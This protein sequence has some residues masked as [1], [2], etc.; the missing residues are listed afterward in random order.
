MIFDLSFTKD[1][2][3][4][5]F[6]LQYSYDKYPK[7][8][9]KPT[10]NE[11]ITTSKYF[12]IEPDKGLRI[13]LH[14][15]DLTFREDSPTNPRTELRGFPKLYDNKHYIAEWNQ[16]IIEF[17]KDYNY[18]FFQVFGATGPNVMARWIANKYEIASNHVKSDCRTVSLFDEIGKNVL[19]KVEFFLASSAGY[20]RLYR[21]G[22]LICSI[23]NSN[24]SGGNNSY[25]KQGIYTQHDNSPA[26]DT[27]IYV[28]DLRLY[29]RYER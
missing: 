7:D 9:N 1:S 4:D 5:Q 23:E 19:W 16:T 17:Q 28:R 8:I 3:L 29:E 12:N 27:V 15:G 26:K 13:A 10:P 2:D 6:K 24:T 25:W 21:N 14:S 20:V 22:N 11:K 18:C